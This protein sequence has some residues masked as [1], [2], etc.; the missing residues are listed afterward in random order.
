[1]KNYLLKYN[2]SAVIDLVFYNPVDQSFQTSITWASGDIKVVKDGV[3]AGNSTN[4]PAIVSGRKVWRLTLTASELS[5]K[6][7]TIE[8]VNAGIVSDSV[9]IQ[10]FGNASASIVNIPATIAVG[11]IAVDAIGSPQLA[12]NTLT[13]DKVAAGFLKAGSIASGELNNIADGVLKRDFSAITGESARCLLQALR[14]SRNKFTIVGTTLTVYKE[15][16]ITPAWTAQIST[17]ASAE[18]IVGSDPA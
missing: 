11:A 4:T 2:E 7:V 15:D 12:A 17:N 8:F 10:T 9:T 1:M 13:S 14:L 6:T 18:P 5:A 16:D 3:D